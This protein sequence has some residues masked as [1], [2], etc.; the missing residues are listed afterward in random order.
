MEIHQRQLRFTG[1][2]GLLEGAIKRTG[3][4]GLIDS[5]DERLGKGRKRRQKKNQ[6]AQNGHS[7][8]RADK[9]SARAVQALEE[10]KRGGAMK[11]PADEAKN[12]IDD[13]KKGDKGNG[14]DNDW[15]KLAYGRQENCYGFI[16]SRPDHETGNQ[17]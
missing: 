8:A 10:E 7:F 4:I 1:L 6:Q 17:P 15:R 13:Q 11:K 14:L 5:R 16:V 9:K 12:E 3:K 2:Y